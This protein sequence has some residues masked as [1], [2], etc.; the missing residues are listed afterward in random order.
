[1]LAIFSPA[2]VLYYFDHTDLLELGI[3][4]VVV[5]IGEHI[6]ATRHNIGMELRA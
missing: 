3:L 4:A 5:G 6:Y 2:G 1:L